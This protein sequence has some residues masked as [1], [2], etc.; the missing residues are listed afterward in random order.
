MALTAECCCAGLGHPLALEFGQLLDRRGVALGRGPQQSADRF[1]CD[2]LAGRSL[3]D[4]LV[5]GLAKGVAGLV[6]GGEQIARG[7]IGGQ[8][9]EAFAHLGRARRSGLAVGVD[10]GGKGGVVNQQQGL[11]PAGADDHD[12]V[13]LARQQ[14]ALGRVAAQIVRNALQLNQTPYP[15]ARGQGHHQAHHAK[16][17][18]QAWRQAN[19]GRSQ[20]GHTKTPK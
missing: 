13:Q 1:F 16:G 8:R 6:D 15:N 18:G 4:E 7:R 3:L 10:A 14:R 2:G 20:E 9:I 5:A 12:G 19:P 11:S 17:Q